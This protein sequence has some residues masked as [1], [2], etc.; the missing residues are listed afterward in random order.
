MYSTTIEIRVRYGETDAM[1]FLYYGNYALYYEV[2]RT[3]MIRQLGIT[4]KSLEADGIFMPVTE[5]HSRFLRPARYDDLLTVKTLLKTWPSERRITFH[6]EI[7]NAEHKLLN[8]G[9]TVLAFVDAG[10]GRS[11]SIP[12]RLADALRPFFPGPDDPRL[13]VGREAAQRD[14]AIAAPPDRSTGWPSRFAT[15]PGRR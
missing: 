10:S 4:Y 2:G 15:S 5:H 6:T 3:D 9:Q 7:Y 11:R 13:R 12:K 8:T 14:S 1:G